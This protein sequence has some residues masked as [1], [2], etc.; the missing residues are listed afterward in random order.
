[1]VFAAA[2]PQAAIACPVCD[3]ASPLYGVVD[4]HKSCLE[5]A[6]KRLPLLGYPVYYRRC[7][8]CALIFCDTFL[9]W[10]PAQFSRHIYNDDYPVVDPDYRSAR[11]L[12]NAR[13]VAERFAEA[14]SEIRVLD[15]GGGNGVCA[16][17]LGRL[18]FDVTVHD[19]LA[20]HVAPAT[21]QGGADL[22]LAF[23]VLEHAPRPQAMLD[24]LLGFL[25]PEGVVLFSTLLQP[26]EIDRLGLGWWY[27]APRNGH[28]SL[29][30][31]QSLARLFQSRGLSL[32][33][34][35][36]GLHLAWRGAPDFARP[37]WGP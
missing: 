11:P 8:G 33:S 36:E 21:L 18:G 30:S 14:R 27:A 15:Y 31:R 29:H 12:G 32:R 16:D 22:I 10:S 35:S 3:A 5:A 20:G 6:G 37:L 7:P 13:M 34:L 28:V 26:V 25:R 23:E 19:R 9:D 4:F 17:E 1:M 24:E 2:A